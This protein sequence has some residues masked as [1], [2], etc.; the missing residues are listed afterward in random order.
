MMTPWMFGQWNRHSTIWLLA[1]AALPFVEE[2]VETVRSPQAKQVTA[3]HLGQVCSI[4]L[5][6]CAAYSGKVGY[7]V[8][9][10]EPPLTY[11][12]REEVLRS[13][14]KAVTTSAG[15]GHGPLRQR[16]VYL[17]EKGLFS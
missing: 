3:L 6:M 10:Y 1:A 14:P 13:S 11:K 12:Q 7:I 8:S 9:L 2:G 15:A 4:R 17:K 16:R 5:A